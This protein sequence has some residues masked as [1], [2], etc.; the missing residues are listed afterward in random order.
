LKKFLCPVALPVKN[1]ERRTPRLPRDTFLG[2]IRMELAKNV[3]VSVKFLVFA[4]I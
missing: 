1:V 3:P 4:R 2:I